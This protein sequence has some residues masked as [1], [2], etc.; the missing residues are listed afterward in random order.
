MLWRHEKGN[1]EH[2][3]KSLIERVL[4]VRRVE[5]KDVEDAVDQQIKD[6]H[7]QMEAQQAQASQQQQRANP[8]NDLVRVVFGVTQEGDVNIN[9]AWAATDEHV[10][11]A[12]G[13]LLYH[14][15]LGNFRDQCVN[16]L[17]KITQEQP[18]LRPF[19]R[20]VVSYW[21]KALGATEPVI[22]PSQVF[23]RIIAR[24]EGIPG[25]SE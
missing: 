21:D 18:K 10:A 23:N 8:N 12:L 9:M 17:G 13:K 24:D 11:E 14:I 22:K 1:T 25:D 3:M 5:R 16:I 4:G 6:F 15:H 19:A 2:R 7:K 20:S